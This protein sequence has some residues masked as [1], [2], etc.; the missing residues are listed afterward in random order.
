MNYKRSSNLYQ[1]V[2]R[3]QSGFQIHEQFFQ[4][5]Q[6]L[7]GRWALNNYFLLFISPLYEWCLCDCRLSNSQGLESAGLV[8]KHSLWRWSLPRPKKIW[9]FK[10]GCKLKLIVS[11]SFLQE[12]KLYH[13]KWNPSLIL[14]CD[15][16]T[17]FGICIKGFI[18]KAGEFLPFFF[19]LFLSNSSITFY[20]KV[21]ICPTLIVDWFDD[22]K[23]TSTL[24][25]LKWAW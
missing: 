1:E 17:V 16:H 6:V 22:G 10:M 15:I 23:S 4:C 25:S 19:F 24:T 7:G 13:I 21:L 3:K 18:P 20:N 14:M 8:Q 9:S 12:F 11:I 5:I 2:I